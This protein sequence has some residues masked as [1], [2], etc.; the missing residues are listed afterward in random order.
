MQDEVI[1]S[2]RSTEML[3]PSMY[4]SDGEARGDFHT[5]SN[6]AAWF[7][8]SSMARIASEVYREERQ[9]QE[10]SDISDRI[11]R[12]INAVCSGDGPTGKRFFEGA[13]ADGSFVMGHD[14]EES[15]TT[16]MPFYGFCAPDDPR[17]LN[18]AALAMTV[19]NPL[20]S[21]ELDAIWWYNEKWSSATFPG[22]VTALAGASDESELRRR[23]ER[24]YKL[25]D[26]DGSPWWWPYPYRA[27]DRARV[28]RADVARKCGWGAGVFLCRLVHDIFGISVDVPARSIR[29]APFAPWNPLSWRGARIG[30]AVFDLVFVNN[31]QEVSVTIVNRNAEHYAAIVILTPQKDTLLGELQVLGARSSG[32]MLVQHWGRES[33]QVTLNLAPGQRAQLRSK[34]R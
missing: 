26:L 9:A 30:T 28:L 23:I 7:A 8:F 18:H 3:F 14:G 15:E 27:T 5:G 22:W 21:P 24:I 19:E 34:V 2:R 29:V 32:E 1:A 4:F 17:L 11:H 13:N 20:Y 16:L 6:V 33:L 10:W 31:Q 12:A 25:T